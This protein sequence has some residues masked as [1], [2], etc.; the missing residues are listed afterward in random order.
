MGSG[1][2]PVQV[3]IKQVSQKSKHWGFRTVTCN[4]DTLS[5]TWQDNNTVMMMTTAHTVEESYY[6]KPFDFR[7]RKDIP[8]S[9]YGV[10]PD[11]NLF[12]LFPRPIVDYNKHMGGSDGN[13]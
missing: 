1:I 3:A 7:R 13:A 12:L 8:E 11:G 9:S 10:S 6:T 4:A 2:P 5:L